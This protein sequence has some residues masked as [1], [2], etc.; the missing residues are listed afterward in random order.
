M[1][2]AV[3]Q[4]ARHSQPRRRRVRHEARDALA[5]AAFSAGASTVLAVVVT[6]LVALAG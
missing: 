3:S 4:P 6:V 5:V 1:S 2:V